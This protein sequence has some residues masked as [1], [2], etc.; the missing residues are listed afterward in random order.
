MKD[1]IVEEIRKARQEHAEAFNHDLD[2]ICR[3]LKRIERECGHPLVSFPPRRLSGQNE[4]TD[5]HDSES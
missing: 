5:P 4:R 3:D 2:A 1:P